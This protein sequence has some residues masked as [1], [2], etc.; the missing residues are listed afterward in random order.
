MLIIFTEFVCQHAN[1]HLT[2]LKEAEEEEGKI[3]SLDAIWLGIN[4]FLLISKF[5]S[6][7]TIT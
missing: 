1:L 3:I 4:K 6:D 7:D 2:A 5:V